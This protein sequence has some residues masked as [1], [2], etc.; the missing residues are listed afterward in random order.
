MEV[1][2]VSGHGQEGAVG[3]KGL[4]KEGLGG[5]RESGR[6]TKLSGKGGSW[7][8]KSRKKKGVVS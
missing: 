5:R 8:G 7:S 2:V 4:F 3:G 6:G 1:V